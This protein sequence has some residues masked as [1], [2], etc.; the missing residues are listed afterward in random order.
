MF[1]NFSSFFFHSSYFFASVIQLWLFMRSYF[2]LSFVSFGFMN[3]L[4]SPYHS[5]CFDLVVK[6]GMPVEDFS[7][8]SF[9]WSGNNSSC[10]SPLQSSVCFNPTRYLQFLQ[11]FFSF[12]GT[13]FDVFN[14]VF[15]FGRVNCS[16]DVILEGR[17]TVL[18][19][20]RILI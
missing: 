7:G 2:V 9:F 13:P 1:L 19:S 4:M 18:I 16:V 20:V 11:V 8:P 15:F 6:S 10:H 12:F 17:I 5:S 3:S 14:P